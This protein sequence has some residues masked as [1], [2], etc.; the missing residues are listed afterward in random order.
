[1]GQVSIQ[2]R[3]DTYTQAKCNPDIAD[4]LVNGKPNEKERKQGRPTLSEAKPTIMANPKTETNTNVNGDMNSNG[5]KSGLEQSKGLRK[6][7]GENVEGEIGEPLLSS[8]FLFF[9]WL[10]L[11]L[12]KHCNSSSRSFFL[13]PFPPG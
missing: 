5:Y 8:V 1:M 11:F 9:F 12:V 13:L 4:N 10:D 7:K 6:R 2:L 3:S